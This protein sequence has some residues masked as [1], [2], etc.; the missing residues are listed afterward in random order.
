[1]KTVEDPQPKTLVW[2]Q[3]C[4]LTR[5]KG[6]VIWPLLLWV[7]GP[8][9]TPT[10]FR[11]THSCLVISSSDLQS[12]SEKG[13]VGVRGWDHFIL[14]R[15]YWVLRGPCVRTFGTSFLYEGTQENLS[16]PE[17]DPTTVSIRGPTEN[18]S[19]LQSHDFLSVPPKKGDVPFLL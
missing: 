1:M 17:A 3:W 19:S 5:T 8:N 6:V 18:Q 13:E 12:R 11:W 4:A 10:L 9:S 2:N 14:G 16:R 7:E 15:T